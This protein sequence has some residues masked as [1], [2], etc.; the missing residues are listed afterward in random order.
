M[1]LY[2]FPVIIN[3]GMDKLPDYHSLVQKGLTLSQTDYTSMF[4]EIF[5]GVQE[6]LT[7]LGAINNE[8]P[9][10]VFPDTITMIGYDT[11]E[12]AINLPIHYLNLVSKNPTELQFRDQLVCF[13]PDKFYVV[14]KYLYWLRLFG[15]EETIHYY[16]RHGDVHFKA[17]FPESF[18]PGFSSKALL[19]SDLEIEA[20]QTIDA[21]A[22]QHGEI[23]VWRNVDAYFAMNYKDYYGKTVE[24][25]AKMPRPEIPITFEM[26]FFL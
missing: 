5:L 15:R 1:R 21:I 2:L 26:E 25:L 16:Q 7:Y 18:P 24:E 3:N 17:K 8:W 14:L 23:P 22:Q 10:F 6:V 11:K 4:S 12:D 19:V 20:R 13:M 9:K